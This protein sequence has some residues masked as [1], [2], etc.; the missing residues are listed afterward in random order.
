MRCGF[1]R[2]VVKT[3]TVAL[4]EQAWLPLLYSEL[5][6]WLSKCVSSA[7]GCLPVP[8][9]RSHVH[10]HAAGVRVR[11]GHRQRLRP[12]LGDPGAAGR[13]GA[14]P[15][16]RL[17]RLQG[18]PGRA[19]R[20]RVPKPAR[21]PSQPPAVPAGPGGPA[22]EAPGPPRGP[23]AAVLPPL[24][25]PQTAAALAPRQRQ[26]PGGLQQRG[27]RSQN[28]PHPVGRVRAAAGAGQALERHQQRDEDR[29][30]AEVGGRGQGL[31][32]GVTGGRRLGASV[33]APGPGETQG[34]PV[35]V[36][37]LKSAANSDPRNQARW[38]N[39][40]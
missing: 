14:L 20:R 15:T 13:R 33:L 30:G 18:L 5:P 23:A 9:W 29:A 10:V 8:A 21:E 36:Y 4:Q 24:P 25:R 32:P 6:C 28:A 34:V 16:A 38:S 40:N 26:R 2:V 7:N 31:H 27:E 35:F 19:A 1:V 11:D 39:R 22:Q 17:P 3:R 37:A 12:G